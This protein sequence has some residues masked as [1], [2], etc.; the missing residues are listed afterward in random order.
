MQPQMPNLPAEKQLKERGMAFLSLH[1]G[2][3]ALHKFR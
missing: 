1:E 3:Q 2:V